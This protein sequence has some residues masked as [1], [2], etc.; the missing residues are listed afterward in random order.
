VAAGEGGAGGAPAELPLD[1][2]LV[3]A[4]RG[5]TLRWTERDEEHG[6]PLKGTFA[7]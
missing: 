3:E 5:A 7:R 1:A 4:V 2:L 6:V